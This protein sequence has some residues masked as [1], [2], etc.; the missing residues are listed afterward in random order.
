MKRGVRVALIFSGVLT[1]VAPFIGLLGTVSGMIKSF[2][3]LGS[4]GVADPEKLSA[5][6]GASLASTA[7]GIVLS[8]I[9]FVVFIGMLIYWLC[10]RN[11]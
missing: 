11:R 10:A 1:V 9:S 3:T 7:S 8:A 5:G 6:I 2:S 4:S